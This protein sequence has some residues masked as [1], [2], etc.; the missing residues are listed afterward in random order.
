MAWDTV[1]PIGRNFCLSFA[2]PIEFRGRNPGVSTHGQWTMLH[3]QLLDLSKTQYRPSVL[4]T[5]LFSWDGEYRGFLAVAHS[6]HLGLLRRSIG[7]HLNF[8]C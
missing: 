3:C 1:W 5:V 2:V 8:A 6:L 4:G 7:V